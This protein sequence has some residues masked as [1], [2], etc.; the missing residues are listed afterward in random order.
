VSLTLP[1]CARCLPTTPPTYADLCVQVVKALLEAGASPEY[2]DRVSMESAF[3]V[4]Q[5]EAVRAVL[6]RGFVECVGGAVGSVLQRVWGV[7]SRCLIWCVTA[8]CMCSP[9]LAH[10]DRTESCTNSPSYCRYRVRGTCL[11]LHN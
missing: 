5:S 4:A 2:A 7:R 1:V 6:V 10:S 9:L 3:D 8:S 11:A